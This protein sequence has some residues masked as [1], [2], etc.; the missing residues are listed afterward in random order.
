VVG[1]L[2]RAEENGQYAADALLRATAQRDFDGLDQVAP[3][4]WRIERQTRL[5]ELD[6]TH[7]GQA[8]PALAWT[9]KAWEAA[10]G[11]AAEPI[12]GLAHDRTLTDLALEAGHQLTWHQRTQA[13]ETAPHPLS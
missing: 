11:D 6:P 3:N 13:I 8:W 7:T 5:I 10:G 12:D 9:T 1:A 4:A 2:R